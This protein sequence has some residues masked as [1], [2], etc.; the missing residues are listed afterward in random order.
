MKKIII[1]LIA[2]L[3]F[4]SSS[5]ALVV[6]STNDGAVLASTILGTGITTS[7]IVYSGAVAASGTFTDGMSSGI[8]IASGILITNGSA[9]DAV[10]PNISS[11][12]STVNNFAGDLDLDTL[13]TDS[14][15]DATFLSF[16]FESAGGDMFFK[17]AFASEEYNE[18]VDSYND[19]FG[20][21]L[22][23]INIALIP[24]TT[25]PVSINNVNLGDNPTLYNDNDSDA[26]SPFN[27]EY[28]GFTD[29]FTAT[30]LGL[31]PGSHSIKLAIADAVDKA[32]DS[33]VFIQAGSFSDEDPTVVPEPSTIM[34]LGGGLIGLA[35]ARRKIKK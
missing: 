1:Y 26:G 30:A 25:T 12:T 10:G 28:D 6:T 5:F 4:A 11:G 22:D 32:L 18:Y 23:G 27:I 13:I 34:L 33:A 21:F 7:N 15:F 3:L 2:G 19:V 29:V 16:D 20:F 14:T 31:T 8:G 35:F 24:G 17:Y 9:S